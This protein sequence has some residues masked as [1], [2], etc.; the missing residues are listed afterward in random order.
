MARNTPIKVRR[1]ATAAVS[2]ALR[3]APFSLLAPESWRA[4]AAIFCSPKN[5]C[6]VRQRPMPSAPSARLNRI[7]RNV[8]IGAN[9]DCAER[10]RPA[11]KLQQFGIIGL[12]RAVVFSLPLMTRPV[13]PSSEI[14]SP[15]L[16][17]CPSHASRAFFPRPR[18]RPR[19]QRSTCP[20][21]ASPRPR[22]WSC[23]RVKSECPRPLPC[24]ECLP[25]WFRRAP[26]SP[27]S[28]APC[29]LLHGFIGGENDL[30]DSRARRRRQ[31]RRQNLPTLPLFSSSRGTRKSV[32][33]VR[34]DAEN[35][36]FLCDQ[37]FFHHVQATRTAARPVRLPLRVCSM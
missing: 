31:A 23:R 10:L 28:C 11:H 7:A 25:A 29:R 9:P 32:K 12:R 13:V 4:C 6:S 34:L 14:Q 8:G 22:G 18:C 27:G 5:M 24:R 37:A 16:N 2:S 17:T 3:G 36:F 33:L 20:C 30:A 35:R 15:A 19:R 1:A 26:G 21:R